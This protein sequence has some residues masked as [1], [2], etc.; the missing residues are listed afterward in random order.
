MLGPSVLCGMAWADRKRDQA[1]MTQTQ[2]TALQVA[3]FSSVRSFSERLLRARWSA[4]KMVLALGALLAVGLAAPQGWSFGTDTGVLREGGLVVGQLEADGSVHDVSGQV[5]G[6]VP[7][8]NVA[9]A[10]TMIKLHARLW[11]S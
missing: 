6:T 11:A 1:F 9:A 5:V 4:R 8:G 7:P 3:R 10:L 2:V